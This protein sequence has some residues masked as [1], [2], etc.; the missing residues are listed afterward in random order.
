[1]SIGRPD[2]QGRPFFH[3]TS[4]QMHI[5]HRDIESR[6]TLELPDVGAW[7]YAGDPNT[8]TWCVAYAMN[9]APVQIW[10]PGQPIPE[11]F[12]E[13]ALNPDWILVAHNDAFERAIEERILAPRYGWPIVPIE[14]HRCTMAMASA[15]ALPAKLKTVAEVLELSA[16]KDDQGSRLMQQMARPRKP[17][18][19]EDPNGIYLARRP[20]EARA[21]LRLLSARCRS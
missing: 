1:V 4:S 6:S 17:R 10:I 19:D 16:R 18:A 20:G 21:A 13:A 14:R 8:G 5:L 7:R 11:E 9:D 12:F 3:F 15:S 2:S